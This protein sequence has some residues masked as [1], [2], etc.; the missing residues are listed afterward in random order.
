MALYNILIKHSDL[1][2]FLSL[3]SSYLTW[4]GALKIS[5]KIP[6]KSKKKAI[7][8]YIFIS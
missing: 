7:T 6:L 5:H 1:K 8:P 3:V 2:T 4:E